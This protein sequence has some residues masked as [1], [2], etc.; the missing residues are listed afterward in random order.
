MKTLA[1]SETTI[2]LHDDGLT[3]T[4][5]PDGSRVEARPQGNPT[6]AARAAALGY[7][8]D[9]ARMS[10]EH[11]IGHSLL[12]EWLGLPESPTLRGVA[13]GAHWPHWPEEEAAVLALAAFS[14]AAGVSLEDV[15][16]D[17][18]PYT[19]DL[20]HPTIAEPDDV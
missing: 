15:A 14:N 10:R 1:I 12:A 19:E 13:S 3:V 2:E 16:R 20:D 6:Y 18:R 11:E 4:V 17:R 8:A 9:V 5:L 7:G